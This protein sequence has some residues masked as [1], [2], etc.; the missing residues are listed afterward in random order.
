MHRHEKTKE[1]TRSSPWAERWQEGRASK[2]CQDV[3][4]AKVR[5]SKQGR[6]SQMDK[7]AT[8]ALKASEL[9]VQAGEDTLSGSHKRRRASGA[10]AAVNR[11]GCSQACGN[12]F[13]LIRKPV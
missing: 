5:L 2:S 10:K 6:Q 12:Y 8:P 4:G 13:R 1:P 7:K 11:L 9:D 3:K